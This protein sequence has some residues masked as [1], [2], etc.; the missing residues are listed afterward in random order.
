ML[1]SLYETCLK[2]LQEIIPES[3]ECYRARVIDAN[4]KRGV[5]YDLEEAS[6]GPAGIKNSESGRMNPEGITYFYVAEDRETALK[7]SRLR[8]N[9]RVLVG[10]FVLLRDLRVIDWTRENIYEKAVDIFSPKYSPT[11]AVYQ[12]FLKQFATQ[13]AKPNE[14]GRDIEYVATQLVAEFVRG[15][16]YDGIKYDSSVGNGYDVVLFYGPSDG[17]VEFGG[18]DSVKAGANSAAGGYNSIPC[19]TDIAK[20]SEVSEFKIKIEYVIEE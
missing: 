1:E 19:Y 16:G 6:I 10:R 15:K 5:D 20:L 12:D 4:L 9:D 3:F 11:M 8:G 17:K 2:E 13:V 7:E 14:L 18:D